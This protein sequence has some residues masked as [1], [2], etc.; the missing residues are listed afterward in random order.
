AAARAPSASARSS[1]DSAPPASSQG[2]GGPNN[3]SLPTCARMRPYG[4]IAAIPR[5]SAKECVRDGWPAS[6]D[7]LSSVAAASALFN[8]DTA[9]LVIGLSGLV[10]ASG[11][12]GRVRGGKSSSQLVST[13]AS[14]KHPTARLIRK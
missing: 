8:D 12:L 5:R 7:F 6:Y 14:N 1:S 2:R 11:S 3:T 4:R 13:S 10:P 9:W